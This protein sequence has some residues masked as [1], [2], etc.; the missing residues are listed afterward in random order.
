MINLI[1]TTLYFTLPGLVANMMP[2]F[3]RNKFNMLAFPIDFGLKING[4]RIFG[5][6]KTFRGF[7]FGIIGGILVCLLQ[8]LIK[9]VSFFS[10]ISYINYSFLN[11]LYVGILFGFAAL[12]GDAIESMIKRQVGIKSGRPFIPFDQLDYLFGIIIFAYFVK[13]MT[14]QMNL[15]LII[16]GFLLHVFVKFMGYHLKIRKNIW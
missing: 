15:I 14:W 9:D 12:F 2:L 3:V 6:H 13:A 1:L 11:S 8:F 4:K 5:S 10:K 7:V 16:F